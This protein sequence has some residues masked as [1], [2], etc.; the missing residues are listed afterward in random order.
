MTCKYRKELLYSG[1]KEDRQVEWVT[2]T[3]QDV[4]FRECLVS[5]M[6]YQRTDCSR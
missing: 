4:R 3:L 5:L 6:G 2:P 1:S